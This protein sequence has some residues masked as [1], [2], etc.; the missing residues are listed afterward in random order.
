[1]A[2]F[3]SNIQSELS[4]L[5]F[6]FTDGFK[7]VRSD[8]AQNRSVINSVKN[9]ISENESKTEATFQ[10]VFELLIARERDRSLGTGR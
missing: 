4:S 2:S 5:K 1:M 3:G 10:E 7:S 6:E 9:K 8:L